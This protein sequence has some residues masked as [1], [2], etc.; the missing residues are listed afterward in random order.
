MGIQNHCVKVVP[1]AHHSKYCARPRPVSVAELGSF[2]LYRDDPAGA[3]CGRAVAN[4]VALTERRFGFLGYGLTDIFRS[5]EL[6]RILTM[7][8]CFIYASGLL[9]SAHNA[10]S[11]LATL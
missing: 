9:T 3:E 4:A 7:R 2:A 11:D 5:L 10:D 6:A 1:Y 8:A